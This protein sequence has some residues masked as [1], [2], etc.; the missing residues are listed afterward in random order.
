MT[1]FFLT[2]MTGLLFLFSAVGQTDEYSK[3][4]QTLHQ[5]GEVYFR[6]HLDRDLPLRQ[7]LEKLSKIVSISSVEKTVVTA[8][9]NEKEFSRFRELGFSYEV[10]TPPSML[11]DRSVVDARNPQT[12]WDFYPSYSEYLDIMDQF[13]ADYP[14]LCEVVNIGTSEEGRELLFLHINDSLGVP[15]NEPE[16]MYT[17]SMHGDEITGYVL[18]LHLI[19]YLL[20]NHGSDDRITNMVNSIDIWINPL[21]NPD[22]TYAGGNESVFGATRYNANFVDLNRNYPDPEDGPHPDGNAYQA[23][24]QAFMDFADAHHF[25]LSANFHGGAEVI[26]YPWDTWAKLTADNDWWVYVCRQYA[27]TAQAHSPAG[28]FTDLNNGITNGYAWYE[29]AGGRQDYMNYEQHCREVTVE[30]SGSKLPSPVQLPDFWEYNYRSFLDYMEQS[31]FGIRG[32]VTD[33]QTGEAVYAEVFIEGH[34]EDQSQVYANLPTGNYNRLIYSGNYTVT[35]RSGGYLPFVVSNV[36]VANDSTTIVNVQLDSLVGLDE[37]EQST[38]GV[39]VFPNPAK[40]MLNI[41]L[42]GLAEEITLISAGGRTF[43]HTVPTTEN[44]RIDLSKF[45]KGVYVLN[46]RLE[47]R[48]VNQKIMIQ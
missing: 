21:A 36:V 37:E 22:G 18:M 38:D 46:V 10:L 34:D 15:Q 16:F 5:R 25:S 26:N 42:T 27:D 39:L 31:L 48:T 33:A 44:I 19:E 14:S 13:V 23:E 45:P 3:A 43:L 1:R 32:L 12:I 47:G 7:Q 30:L 24:T 2:T 20:E 4:Q 35:Y 41:H 28:Y 8:Y 6:F 9:A 17:S 40:N 11:L 29:V